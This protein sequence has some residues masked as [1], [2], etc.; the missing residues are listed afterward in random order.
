MNK[1]S[2]ALTALFFGSLIILSSCNKT[3]PNPEKTAEEK[4]I[5]LLT[6]TWVV[7]S[8]VNAITI[9]GV[10][11]S[12]DWASFVLTM[13]NKTYNSTGANQPNVW[14]SSGTWDFATSGSTVD[15]NTIIRSSVGSALEISINVTENTLRMQFDY[16]TS[17]NGKLSGTDGTWIFNMVPQ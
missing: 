9:G 16:D 10:D 7:K 12:T 4:Q 5:D 2:Y 3:T 13:G 8:G 15:I 11:V 17:I 6:N 1:L 14:P